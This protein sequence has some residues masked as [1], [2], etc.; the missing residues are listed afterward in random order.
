MVAACRGYARVI[1]KLGQRAG[2]SWPAPGCGADFAEHLE[3]SKSEE[4]LESP[5]WDKSGWGGRGKEVAPPTGAAGVPEGN[6]EEAPYTR[7][8]GG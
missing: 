4:S 6:L 2:A 8:E 5:I 7:V 1:S 3:H